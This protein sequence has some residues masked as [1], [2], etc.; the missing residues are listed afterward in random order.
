MDWNKK[1]VLI[2][3]AAGF[4]G[5]HLTEKLCEL[6]ADITAFIR[7]NSRND[8]GLLELLNEINKE[9]INVI[10]GDLRD[11]DAIRTVVKETDY[12]FEH[13]IIS[14]RTVQYA[15]QECSFNVR[16]WEVWNGDLEV[17]GNI[18]ENPE[19]IKQ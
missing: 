14:K 3:G 12:T 4:I 6:G 5:S 2:T 18:Y 1:K 10:S 19:L 7:Y 17:I 11:S 8:W 15:S 16:E 9:K 13:P